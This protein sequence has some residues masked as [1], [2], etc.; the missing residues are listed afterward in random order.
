MQVKYTSQSRRYN[1]LLYLVVIVQ[2]QLLRRF[3]RHLRTRQV[4]VQV[5]RMLKILCG[6]VR[7]LLAGNAVLVVVLRSTRM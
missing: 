3:L 4:P 5:V 2:V 7:M 6:F 1:I